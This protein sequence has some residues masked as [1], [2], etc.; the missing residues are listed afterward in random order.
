MNE[1]H[2][3]VSTKEEEKF[4]FCAASGLRADVAVVI[5]LVV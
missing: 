5:P 3:S 4:L 2:A 1:L